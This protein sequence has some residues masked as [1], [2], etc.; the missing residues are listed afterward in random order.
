MKG[1]FIYLP[2]LFILLTLSTISSACIE[3]PADITLDPNPSTDPYSTPGCVWV[4]PQANYAGDGLAICQN[5]D[6]ADLT[7]FFDLT[8]GTLADTMVSIRLGDNT[9]AILYQND[10]W[11]STQNPILVTANTA[12]LSSAFSGAS[13][14]SNGVNSFRIISE[15]CFHVFEGINYSGNNRRVCRNDYA[16]SPV[17]SNVISS[18]AVPPNTKVFMY[19]GSISQFQINLSAADAIEVFTSSVSDLSTYKSG[20]HNNNIDYYVI[21]YPV[22]PNCAFIYKDVNFATSSD[23]TTLINSATRMYERICDYSGNLSGVWDN[24]IDSISV[25]F[26]TLVILFENANFGGQWLPIYKDISN[27]NV[28]DDN[29]VD[30]VE[31][32]YESNSIN[33]ASSASSM[34]TL[35]SGCI[36]IIDD[37]DRSKSIKVCHC[38]GH[39][40]REWWERKMDIVV[41]PSTKIGV[42]NIR[43]NANVFTLIEGRITKLKVGLIRTIVRAD[44]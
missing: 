32:N 33:W 39:I 8:T 29:T 16:S 6:I 4:Y 22:G 38:I 37:E 9:I 5:Q 23:S 44:Y 15:G 13:W 31:N 30:H 7:D 35:K 1:R 24:E 40:P 10:G 14:G 3:R 25:D 18:I 21:E 2:I 12:D 34:V 20:V 28:I 19:N 36:F 41:G 11:G 42:G 26:G 43:S 17:S 27:F